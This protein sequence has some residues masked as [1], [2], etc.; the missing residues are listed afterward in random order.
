M[1][2]LKIYNIIV[3][4]TIKVENKLELS[5]LFSAYGIKQ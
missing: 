3:E 1:I 4:Y 5:Y 2:F